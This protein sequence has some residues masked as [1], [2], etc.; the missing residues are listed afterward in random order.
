MAKQEVPLTKV[1]EFYILG[2]MEVVS[3]RQIAK[4]LGVPVAQVRKFKD[5]RSKVETP[6]VPDKFDKPRDGVVSMTAEASSYNDTAKRRGVITQDVINR[7]AASGDYKLAA[8]L[9][10]LK[11][12]QQY[13]KKLAAR[14]ATRDRVMYLKD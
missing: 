3:D 7:A 9:A 13:D 12:K 1:Q 8:E 10:E 5:E 11:E 14:A 2:N 4:D 6:K